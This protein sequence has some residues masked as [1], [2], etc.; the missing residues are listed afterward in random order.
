MQLD[1]LI[2]VSVDDHVV[3]P[4]DL[5]D[6]RLEAKWADRAPKVVHKDDDTDVWVFEG[7]EIPNV[8]LN[9]VAGRPPEEYGV[10]PTSFEE[11]RPGAWDVDRRIDDMNANGVLASMN[12]PS[13]PQFCGQIFNSCEDK[14]LAL[15][16]LTAYN[17][18]HVDT[19]CGSHPG[20]FIP[21]GLVP[22]W[23]PQLMAAEVRR[24]AAK[25]CHAVTWS[26]NPEKLGLPSFHNTH[27]DP[28][29]AACEDTGTIVCLHI[30]SSGQVVITSMEAPITTMLT[31]QPVNLLQ[32]AADL[33]WSSVLTRFPK[34]RFALS[35]GGIGWIPYFLERADYVF[36]NHQT[37]TGSGFGGKLPSEVFRERFATCFIDDTHGLENREKVG[38]ET[39]CWE[40]DYP[41]SDS[42]WPRSPEMLWASVQEAGL[43]DEEIRAITYENASRFFSFDPFAHRSRDECTVGALRARAAGI[44]TS[45]QPRRL[46]HQP[47]DSPLTLLDLLN[48]ADHPLLDEQKEAAA[49]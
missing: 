40:A 2:L 6:G 21:L 46:R 16:V 10:E 31:L 29:W 3:E 28:F 14:E 44:D 45:P 22:Y 19:W 43:S 30:G 26:E 48:R 34:V 25:G 7:V 9:A 27:W 41:H 11:I 8:G 23:D 37:W 39:I 12:F 17:D 49:P 15:P 38:V 42:S 18:W 35:E 36:K 24:L 32:T 20:R 1:D 5:F 4:P 33:L 47:P 13:F